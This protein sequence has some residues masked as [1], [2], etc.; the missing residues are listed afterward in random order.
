ML[1]KLDVHQTP[2]FRILAI[3]AAHALVKYVGEIPI[4]INN[5]NQQ[6]DIG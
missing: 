1:I 2:S 6:E 5:P 3:H 4:K